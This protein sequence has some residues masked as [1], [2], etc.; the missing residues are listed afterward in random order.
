[1]ADDV[2]FVSMAAARASGDAPEIGIGLLGYAFMGKAHSN[3]FKTLP[4][5][6]YPPVAIPRLAAICGRSEEA[7]AEAARR[8]GYERYY[9]DWRKMLEDPNV[10]VFDNGG[11]NDAHAE[12]CIA[13]AE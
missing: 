8:Y 13:A 3:A 7:V 2:G 6:M 4:Y 9:T 10:Q 11:P 5:M 1:M 12:P